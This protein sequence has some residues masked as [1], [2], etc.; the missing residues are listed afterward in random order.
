M[1]F[2]TRRCLVTPFTR[3]LQLAMYTIWSRYAFKVYGHIRGDPY[4]LPCDAMLARVPCI[5]SLF[6]CQFKKNY[7]WFVTG[8]QHWWVY[9]LPRNLSMYACWYAIVFVTWQINSSSSSSAVW[10]YATSRCSNETAERIQLGCMGSLSILQRVIRKVVY[11]QNKDISL[12]L[13]PNSG[14]RKFRHGKSV[15]LSTKLVDARAYDH[16]YNGRRVVA[17]RR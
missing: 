3:N 11:L 8:G 6:I 9:T 16:T 14:L 12:E 7:L 2:W 5:I 13:R 1:H 17:R 10:A 15:E 4:F